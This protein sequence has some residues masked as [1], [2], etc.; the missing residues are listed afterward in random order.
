MKIASELGKFIHFDNQETVKVGD[1][2][3]TRRRS[4]GSGPVF[5]KETFPNATIREE[6]TVLTPRVGRGRHD[7][8]LHQ[9]C[10]CL[11]RFCEAGAALLRKS[12]GGGA[13]KAPGESSMKTQMTPD[14]M[15]ACQNDG[16]DRNSTAE[17]D[18]DLKLD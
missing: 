6:M 17:R 16:D 8:H 18:H 4:K 14:P 11:G 10:Q 2:K 5:A 7:A 12:S 15:C 9:H 1:W 13:G 3:R